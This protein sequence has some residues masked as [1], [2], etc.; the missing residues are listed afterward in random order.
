[1]ESGSATIGEVGGEG[2]IRAPVP[3]KAG[4]FFSRH[5]GKSIRTAA[6]PN[7]AFLEAM[8]HPFRDTLPSRLARFEGK[9]IEPKPDR[10]VAYADVQAWLKMPAAW[11]RGFVERFSPR[12]KDPEF[13]KQVEAHVASILSG[14]K[15]C[16]RKSSRKKNPLPD[17]ILSF[18]FVE[19]QNDEIADE[20]QPGAPGG[21]RDR[22]RDDRY[23]C[24]RLLQ[25]NAR[26][27]IM[28]NARIMMEAALAVR[29]YTATQI[30][31]LLDTQM[32][33]TFLPS[34]FQRTRPTATSRNCRKN[35]RSTP[36]KRRR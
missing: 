27:E 13:R 3:A 16:I 28:E 29:T 34:R 19:G 30:K 14:T 1:V 35:F 24:N 12:L 20:N 2:G 7:A 6:R 33:Y 36:T 25:Q 18:Y 8:P 22:V 10:A 5:A 21:L 15:L 23:V 26:A 31:P 17:R 11:R 9:S 32:K 4:Q